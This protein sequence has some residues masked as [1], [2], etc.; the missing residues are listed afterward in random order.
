MP[1]VKLAFPPGL[2]KNGTEYESAARFYDSDLVR[3]YKDS[4]RPIGGWVQLGTAL[5][6]TARAIHTWLDVNAVSRA[7]I[8]TNSK[9]YTLTPV[10]TLTDITPTA[11]TGEASGTTWTLDNGGAQLFGVNDADGVIYEWK[12]G[13][14]QAAALSGAPTCE[15]LFVTDEF[16]LVAIAAGGDPRE[17]RWSDVRNPTQWTAAVTNFA[18][19]YDILSSARLMC[20]QKVLGGGLIWSSEDLH[21]LRYVGL[22]DVYSFERIADNCG[23]VSRKAHVR[24]NDL[25]FWM[26]RSQFFVYAGR[27]LVQPLPCDIQD[28]VFGAGGLNRTYQHLV[29][30]VHVEEFNEVWWHFPRGSATENSH[31]AVYNYAEQHWTHHALVRTA[32]VE[33]G[34]GFSY[35]LMIGSGGEVWQHENG[36]TRTGGGRYYLRSG[37]LELG[38]GD[39]LMEA[40]EAIP[41]ETTSGDV[42][43]DFY[44]RLYPNAAEV[45]HGPYTVSSSKLDIRLSGRQAA[46]RFREKAAQNGTSGKIGV[47]RLKVQSGGER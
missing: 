26:S 15:A 5:T 29:R 22:P 32:G 41:D 43:V 47:Y 19:D 17:V 8:G 38:E 13:D 36:N 33:R 7:A 16:I 14:A 30:A 12:P 31:V 34:N 4:R 10:G 21:L 39:Q 42:E 24:A 28:W 20:G 23:T 11:F 37:P 35:P 6:G 1:F 2:S 9:L 25:I 18:G 46:I 27:G 45:A 44:T 3:F 40:F